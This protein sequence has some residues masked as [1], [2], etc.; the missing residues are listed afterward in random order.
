[1]EIQELRISTER[2]GTLDR[3]DGVSENITGRFVTDT[4]AGAGLIGD[5]HSGIAVVPPGSI[6]AKCDLT[7]ALRPG[8]SRE[9]AE[10][11]RVWQESDP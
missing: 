8:N 6:W 4:A 9:W 7:L 10:F 5:L 3:L 11:G 2:W 1:M